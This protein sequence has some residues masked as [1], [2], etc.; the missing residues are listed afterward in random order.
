MRIIR[1]FKT[2]PNF[3]YFRQVI[4]RET[5]AGPVPL[6]EGTVDPEI[7]SEA[8]GIPFQ[9]ERYFELLNISDQSSPEMIMLGVKFLELHLAFYKLVGYD[10]ITA[11]PT[12]PLART[13]WQ[14]KANPAQE[15]KT[16]LWQN[17]HKGV[18]TSRE[19]FREF[20]WPKPDQWT[21]ASVYVL[22]NRLPPGAKFIQFINGIFEEMRALMGFEAFAIKSMEEPELVNDILEKSTE[23]VSSLMEKASAHPDVGAIYYCDDMSFN[24][25]P[26]A[27][28]GWFREYVF[29]R[30]KKLVDIAHQHRKPVLFHSCG[31]S[32]LLMKD[33]IET[34][35]I[36]AYHSFQDN[37]IPVEEYYKRY[38]DQIAI[39]GGVDVDLLARGAP[40]QVRKR[41]REILEV[42]GIGGGFAIG[43]GNSVTNFCKLENYYA[44]LDETRKWNEEHGWK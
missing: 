44:M 20:P 3:E 15:G 7:M 40:G 23:L 38:H 24:N 28:P 14:L 11:F 33:L 41:T 42:C 37:V 16:R 17:E 36:D 1:P 6:F 32:E 25:G 39:L 8:T 34:I 43:S 4:K 35:G 31:R 26:M 21:I 12:T 10:F 22:Q 9:F 13:P 2:T 30:Q 18:I 19:E 29:P 5:T 27:S